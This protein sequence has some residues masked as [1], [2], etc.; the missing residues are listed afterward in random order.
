MRFIHTGWPDRKSSK[1]TI[2]KRNCGIVEKLPKITVILLKTCD[3]AGANS[4]SIAN[5]I[6]ANNAQSNPLF[7]KPSSNPMTNNYMEPRPPSYRADP[8]LLV[9]TSILIFKWYYYLYI[10]FIITN[11]LLF[12]WKWSCDICRRIRLL[13]SASSSGHLKRKRLGSRKYYSDWCIKMRWCRKYSRLILWVYNAQWA[14]IRIPS[15]SSAM[16]V[17]VCINLFLSYGRRFLKEMRV[18]CH[19]TTQHTTIYI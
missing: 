1:R 11:K 8:Q 15:S 12:V 6:Y 2:A 13:H 17:V 9:F 14:R 4:G 3:R 19:H 5:P 7:F 10:S 18:P 16:T